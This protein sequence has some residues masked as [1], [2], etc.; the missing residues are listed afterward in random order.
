MLGTL[1][2][3]RRGVC[4]ARLERQ[5]AEENRHSSQE[6]GNPEQTLHHRPSLSSW[7]LRTPG[8]GHSQD[9]FGR[10]DDSSYPTPTGCFARSRARARQSVLKNA[11]AEYGFPHQT[12]RNSAKIVTDPPE[13]HSECSLRE[14]T[15]KEVCSLFNHSARGS[16]FSSNSIKKSRFP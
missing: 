7:F 12:C 8:S 4:I 14:I 6:H 9:G 3:R 13:L 1:P 11:P 5:S 10:R 16:A 2:A 15:I